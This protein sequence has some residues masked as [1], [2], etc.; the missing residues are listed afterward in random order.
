[1]IFAS[2]WRLIWGTFAFKLESGM[3]AAGVSGGG[4]RLEAST[5]VFCHLGTFDACQGALLQKSG[6]VGVAN[7]RLILAG[8]FQLR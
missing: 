5:Y 2:L 7:L 4:G 3:L 1:M 8:M 6:E